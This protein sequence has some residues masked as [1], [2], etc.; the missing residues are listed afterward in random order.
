[1]IDFPLRDVRCLFLIGG[2]L[3]KIEFEL[4]NRV[5]EQ[6]LERRKLASR[7]IEPLQ[8]MHVSHKIFWPL[9]ASCQELVQR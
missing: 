9:F 4:P 8:P 3:L 6:M 5:P 7:A 2:R 1:M